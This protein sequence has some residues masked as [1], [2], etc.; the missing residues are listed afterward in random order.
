MSIG[1]F[2]LAK[3]I[4]ELNLSSI[5][6]KGLEATSSWI[7]LDGGSRMVIQSRLLQR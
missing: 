5:D 7:F 3:Y 1:D 6:P 2:I 4:C